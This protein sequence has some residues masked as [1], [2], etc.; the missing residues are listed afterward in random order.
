[1]GKQLRCT[2]IPRKSV[3][4]NSLGIIDFKRKHKRLN[5]VEF[6]KEAHSFV[7]NIVSKNNNLKV[8]R[9]VRRTQPKLKFQANTWQAKRLR[10][11][12]CFY[13]TPDYQKRGDNS[14]F[15]NMTEMFNRFVGKCFPKEFP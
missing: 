7:S 15:V 13:A 12:C 11:K 8:I 14:L 9:R 1:M 6:R 5:E 4:Y 3:V 2:T 10:R